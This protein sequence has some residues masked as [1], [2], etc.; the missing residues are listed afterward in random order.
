[1]NLHTKDLID[2]V[3]WLVAQV[4][5]LFRRVVVRLIIVA[6]RDS[7]NSEHKGRYVAASLI[8]IKKRWPQKMQ[9]AH[10]LIADPADPQLVGKTFRDY[11]MDV[12]Q[13]RLVLARRVPFLLIPAFLRRLL[14]P[15]VRE[16]LW[17]AVEM[18]TLYV[19]VDGRTY[20]YGTF[21][22]IAP[23]GRPFHE[24]QELGLEWVWRLHTSGR[25]F[26]KYLQSDIPA[27][28]SP[29]HVR[30]AKHAR[31]FGRIM[32]LVLFYTLSLLA[33]RACYQRTF[34]QRKE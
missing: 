33:Y 31:R 20:F 15:S 30:V 8:W 18:Y 26:P 34:G 7:R 22:E 21:M 16:P 23:A 10:R 14:L 1:M 17:W 5:W 13:N 11:G 25:C 27:Q 4:A 28:M 24:R 19:V 6:S 32:A 2:P 29:V 3:V 9:E 12:V